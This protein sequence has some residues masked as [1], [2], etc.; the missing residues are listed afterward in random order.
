MDRYYISITAWLLNI[1]KR[2]AMKPQSRKSMWN[3]Y[4]YW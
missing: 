3:I 4:P 2:I 1:Y